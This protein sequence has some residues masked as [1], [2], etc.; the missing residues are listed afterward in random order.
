MKA[1]AKIIGFGEHAVVYGKS[2]IAF[3]LPDLCTEVLIT[4]STRLSYSTDKVLFKDEKQRLD[5]LIEFIFKRLG[6]KK[7]CR[8]R[9]KSNI[10]VSQGLGSSAA[11]SIAL[12]KALN[13]YF[14]LGLNL[15]DIR[16]LSLECEKIFHGNP[17]GIDSAVVAFEK[18]IFFSKGLFESIDLKK[19]LNLVIANA[20]PRPNTREVVEEVRKKYEND[21][22]KFSHIFYEIDNIAKKAKKAIEKGFVKELGKLMDKNHLYLHE[23]GVSSPKLDLLVE[24]AKEKG[25]LGAKL[26]GAGKGGNMIALINEKDKD[27]IMDELKKLS[28]FVYFAKIRSHEN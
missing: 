28:K 4:G 16:Q 3:P 17:S 10:P 8:I 24:A 5:K 25:A 18:P 14:R 2:G 9:I 26:S 15:D 13:L 6:L 27:K 11:L 1:C 20:G 23:I 7:R 21:K 22:D 12:L 19:S